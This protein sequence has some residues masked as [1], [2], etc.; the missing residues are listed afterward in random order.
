MNITKRTNKNIIIT[1]K[2]TEKQVKTWHKILFLSPIFIIIL[3]F[4]VNDWYRSYL[5]KKEPQKTYATIVFVTT[6]GI[7]SN[8]DVDNVVIEY[9]VKDSLYRATLSVPINYRHVIGPINLP[10]L[11]G[12]EYEIIYA[13]SKPEIFDLNL[14]KPSRKTIDSFISYSIDFVQNYKNVP[15]RVAICIVKDLLIIY[16]F[17]LFS[18]L[19][20]Y[21]DAWI[22]NFQFNRKSFK[23][24]W[25]DSVVVSICRKCISDNLY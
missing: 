19:Y 23:S 13:K 24:F 7:D 20:F 11:P 10:I 2:K 22:E 9:K 1:P 17:S 14:Y 4:K 16:K 6:T 21:D 25:K 3:I 5:L 12:Q 18:Y 15:R 8:L